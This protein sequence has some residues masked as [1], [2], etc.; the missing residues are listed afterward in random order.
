MAT[1]SEDKGE[2]DE[3]TA[4]AELPFAYV[5]VII[6]R[7]GGNS[8]KGEAPLLSC[9]E[10]QG[11]QGWRESEALSSSR[12][13]GWTRW[14]RARQGQGQGHIIVLLSLSRHWQ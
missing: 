13:E 8:G 6:C 3:A 5:I 14:M 2:V 1:V 9:M 11:G 4:L 10:G 12:V 7:C